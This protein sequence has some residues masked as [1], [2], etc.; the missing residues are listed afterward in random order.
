MLV[1]RHVLKEQQFALIGA[2]TIVRKN[3]PIAVP[4][5][6][7]GGASLLLDRD[8]K[9]ERIEEHSRLRTGRDIQTAIE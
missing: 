8:L 4:S 1:R 3:K 9:K 7:L 6:A 2:E 5:D